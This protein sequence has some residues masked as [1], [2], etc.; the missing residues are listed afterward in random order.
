MKECLRLFTRILGLGVV[1]LAVAG[2]PAL[3][4]P[5]RQAP[6][7]Q[8]DPASRP[9]QKCVHGDRVN[10]K[11]VCEKGWVGETC[12]TPQTAT[13]PSEKCA[14]GRVANGGCACEKGWSGK[15][16]ETPQA[17]TRPG[18][19]CAHGDL[20]N[21]KCVC[22]KGWSGKSCAVRATAKKKP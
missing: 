14:H 4:Q 9:G 17:A 5:A 19:K 2:A 20:V 16:C 15:T 12:A 10:G 7:S 3:A 11:C 1:L 8:Q 21:G 18:E 22:E 13:R 6:E